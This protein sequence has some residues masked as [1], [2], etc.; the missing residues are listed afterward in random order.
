MI[1]NEWIIQLSQKAPQYFSIQM[2]YN[3]KIIYNK[4]YTPKSSREVP[5]LYPNLQD[6]EYPDFGDIKMK[7]KPTEETT[8][9]P[10]IDRTSKP[11]SGLKSISQQPINLV[12]LARE[13]ETMYDQILEKDNE[14]LTIGKE[15]S[16][17][18]SSSKLPSESDQTEWFNKQTELEYKFIQK[19]NELNDNISE[20]QSVNQQE[21]E[22]GISLKTLQ[23]DQNPEVAAI[24]ARLEAKERVHS[25]FEQKF[26]EIKQNID[27]RSLLLREK[28]KRHFEVSKIAL[29]SVLWNDSK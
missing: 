13:K 25:Q 8:Y 24:T 1:P 10:R 22:E 29:F 20:L 11:T 3:I 14:V 6:I 28:Q 9:I 17:M 27:V 26:K 4:R 19:E 7:P 23:I 21:S 16:R 18:L 2:N 12:A 5:S 15:L